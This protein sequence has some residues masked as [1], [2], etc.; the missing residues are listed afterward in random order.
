MT[1]EH[2][3]D[4]TTSLRPLPGGASGETFLAGAGEETTVLRVYAGRSA[5][6]GPLA[7]EVDAA[8]L[9][10]VRGVLPVAEVLEVRRG[11]PGADLPGLLVV[12]RLP[13]EPLVE[14]LPD[15]DDAGLRRVGEGLGVL[16]GRLG[17]AVQPRR[18]L[19]TD[20]RLVADRRL[21]TLHELLDPA[22][23]DL[24]AGLADA[25][26]PVLDDADGLLA[27]DSRSVLVHGDLNPRNV[28]V[29][30]ASLV[31]T[32]LVDWEFAH[33]GGPW[34][35]LGNLL[36]HAP[37][38]P[39]RDG[40]LASYASLVPGLPAD[41]EDLVARA[42]AADLAALVDLAGRAGDTGPGR[43]ALGVLAAAAG[44]TLDAGG[45]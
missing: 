25:L 16:A 12:S 11:D 19:F 39:L 32:G 40:V 34:E 15:L 33:A 24:P 20:H 35:D 44:W 7:P 26:R 14:V 6:R 21:P 28:L 2:A 10:L 27:G 22:A 13:G 3:G 1:Q 4:F 29:D 31:V 45:A 38:G 37:D 30:P 18:G 17:L 41:R 8:V 42:E 9:R 36:R 23:A 43:L 5:V